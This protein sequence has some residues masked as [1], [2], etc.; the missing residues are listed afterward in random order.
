MIILTLFV[1]I[2]ISVVAAWYSILG[3]MAI[4]AA[5]AIPIAI[6]GAVLEVGK[7]VTASWL[8]QNWNTVPKLLKGYLTTSV[9]VLM[10]IT[11]MGIFGFLSKAHID[12][13]ILTGDNSLQI[14]QIDQKIDRE[15][16]NINDAEKVIDT[17]DQQVQTLIDYDRIRGPEGALATRNNQKQEREQLNNIIN[18]SFNIINDLQNEKLTLE[19][20]QLELEAEVGPIRYI[21]EFVY[22]DK[23]SK[24][25]LEEAVRWV[26][27]I[28]IFVFDPLAV[29]LLIAAN[30][31]IKERMIIKQQQLKRELLAK[32]REKVR[33]RKIEKENIKNSNAVEFKEDGKVEESEVKVT[34]KEI[35]E[36]KVLPKNRYAQ[37]T[38]I[39]ENG[40]QQKYDDSGTKIK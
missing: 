34:K 19:K 26:I 16:R 29:L 15:Q 36:E 14:E 10:F 13:T 27:I 17:L 22:R 23:A 31:S 21:A 28:I 38:Y 18:E 2:A 5:A 40:F 20:G 30:I 3:L 25:V 11:S 35:K 33:L 32:K 37:G 4:F 39:D 6:M 7:L 9:V 12:Q 24:A 1:A 8:Y